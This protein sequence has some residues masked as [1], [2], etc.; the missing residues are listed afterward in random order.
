MTGSRLEGLAGFGL[1]RAFG[2]LAARGERVA[3]E[4]TNAVTSRTALGRAP[5]P[6]RH[7]L[8]ATPFSIVVWMASGVPPWI[9]ACRSGSDRSCP[10]RAC[11]GRRRTAARR[12]SRPRRRRRAARPALEHLERDGRRVREL[13]GA[14]RFIA[15]RAATYS[16]RATAASGRPRSRAN[17]R[18]RTRSSEK[19]RDPPQR[20]LVVGLFDAVVL[21]DDRALNRVVSLRMLSHGGCPPRAA[22]RPSDLA[23]ACAI[24][25]RTPR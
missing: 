1:E 22:E 5:D 23:S 20:Q 25:T 13:R 9:T 24:E 19:R 10:R 8:A 15:W 18:G 17:T 16:D 14:R 11:R 6:R 2:R 3:R 12:R 4:S 21:V 7:A